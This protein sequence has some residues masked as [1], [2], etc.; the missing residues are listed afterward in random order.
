MAS[1]L[2][3]EDQHIPSFSQNSCPGNSAV[4]SGSKEDLT[5]TESVSVRP[6]EVQV[7]EMEKDGWIRSLSLLPNFNREK[8]DNQL[9]KNSATMPNVS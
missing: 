5:N 1:S 6:K 2:E 8:L 9:I 4:E 7:R 3:F